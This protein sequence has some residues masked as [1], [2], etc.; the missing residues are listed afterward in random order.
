VRLG[1]KKQQVIE[2][3]VQERE[4][5]VVEPEVSDND[6]IVESLNRSQAVI[7]FTPNGDILGA[8]ENFL[9]C[10]GY[11][12]DEVV[13]RHHRLFVDPTEAASDEYRSFWDSLAQGTFQSAEYRRFGKGGN[14][15]W[16]QATYNPVFDDDGKVL[17]VIK[18]A[19]DITR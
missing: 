4:P 6:R 7:E 5:E 1:T 18:F 9:A 8:N 12:Q 15:I 17:K 19:T 3:P 13:G 14:E 11:R 10:L 16:I 2:V